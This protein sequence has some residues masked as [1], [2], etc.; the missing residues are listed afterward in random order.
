MQLITPKFC[1]ALQLHLFIQTDESLAVVNEIFEGPPNLTLCTDELSKKLAS[2]VDAATFLTARSKCITSTFIR[3]DDNEDESKSSHSVKC[4]AIQMF[5]NQCLCNPLEINNEAVHLVNLSFWLQESIGLINGNTNTSERN[6]NNI[7]GILKSKVTNVPCLPN[8]PPLTLNCE[9][10]PGSEHVINEAYTL[11][12]TDE[13]IEMLE[14]WGKQEPARP[15]VKE[16]IFSLELMNNDFTS[17]K[18]AQEFTTASSEWSEGETSYKALTKSKVPLAIL[19]ED[20]SENMLREI[21]EHYVT[22]FKTIFVDFEETQ[23]YFEDAELLTYHKDI[24]EGILDKYGTREC[25]NISQSDLE[26]KLSEWF[27]YMK[28]ENNERKSQFDS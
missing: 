3:S 16:D 2:V 15:Q 7:S 21:S 25:A 19:R 5:L 9:Q 13:D 28:D 11:I 12:L 6:E 24:S 17:R 23:V 1:N 10:E 22:S 20:E 27:R 8:K 4:E 18:E 14:I 26:S